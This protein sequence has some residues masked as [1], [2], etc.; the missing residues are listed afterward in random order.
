MTERSTKFVASEAVNAMKSAITQRRVMAIMRSRE[1]EATVDIARALVAGGIRT[2]EIT[3][4]NESAFVALRRVRTALPPDVLVGAGT[5]LD[6]AQG[7]RA[8]DLGASFLVSPHLDPHLHRTLTNDGFLHIP[9]VATPSEVHG[10]ARIGCDLVKLFPAAYLGM[11]FLKALQGPFPAMQFMATGGVALPDVRG[12]LD[13]GASAVGIGGHLA[14]TE[15]PSPKQLHELTRL[16]Q[17]LASTLSDV[18]V[19][20]RGTS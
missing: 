2:V 7:R 13:A 8:V 18:D 11:G 14:P 15:K 12:W 3:V 4:Q 6:V 17:S 16:A 10:A 19:L 20:A 9:G 1:H 5:V